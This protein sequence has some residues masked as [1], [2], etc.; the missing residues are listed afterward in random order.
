MFLFPGVISGA[1]WFPV[2]LMTWRMWHTPALPVRGTFTHTSVYANYQQLFATET[3]TQINSAPPPGSDKRS[4]HFSTV[5][6]NPFP[7]YLHFFS[8]VHTF[9]VYI[10]SIL[11]LSI[12]ALNTEVGCLDILRGSGPTVATEP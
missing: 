10:L 7:L 4:P 1:A 2:S 8:C 5:L 3:C 11:I 6:C 12:V 9:T